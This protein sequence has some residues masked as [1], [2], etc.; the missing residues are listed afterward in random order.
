MEGLRRF[1]PSERR[2]SAAVL[3]SSSQT[4]V[5]A[6]LAL[7]FRKSLMLCQTRIIIL[8]TFF[9]HLLASFRSIAK[10]ISY[11]GVKPANSNNCSRRVLPSPVWLIP[12][13]TKRR[14]LSIM[15][16]PHC[17]TKLQKRQDYGAISWESLAIHRSLSVLS[18]TSMD[19]G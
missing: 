9:L 4:S 12:P 16:T 2:D 3:A 13:A 17:S 18:R 7:A 5:V 8:P 11:F 15:A 6:F 19:R 1:Y 14:R 10:F